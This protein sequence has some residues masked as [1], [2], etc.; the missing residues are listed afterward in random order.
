MK[1]PKFPGAVF[2]P[3]NFARACWPERAFGWLG[4]RRGR[5]D[6]GLGATGREAGAGESQ[7]HS[8]GK[9]WTFNQY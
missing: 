6:G 8:F 1:C 9:I 2:A 4:G 5:A 7:V 3:G